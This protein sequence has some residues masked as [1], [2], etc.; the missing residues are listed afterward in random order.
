MVVSPQQVENTRGLVRS[1]M[2]ELGPRLQE[3]LLQRQKEMDNWVR[4]QFASL[5]IKALKSLPDDKENSDL[6]DSESIYIHLTVFLRLKFLLMS[7]PW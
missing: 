7:L 2:K 3:G 6:S 5:L 1:F 4:R